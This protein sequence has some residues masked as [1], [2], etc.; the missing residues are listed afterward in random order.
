MCISGAALD[1]D[2]GDACTI[3]SCAEPEGC[4]HRGAPGCDAGRGLDGGSGDGGP[5]FATWGCGCRSI[6]GARSDAASWMT[7]LLLGFALAARRR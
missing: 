5:V 2:D 3:D 6:A 7:L 4:V 1:C